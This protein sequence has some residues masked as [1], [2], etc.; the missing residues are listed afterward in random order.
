MDQADSFR[1]SDDELTK[2]EKGC[3]SSSKAQTLTEGM[4]GP[5]LGPL[6][7]MG[8]F[9]PLVQHVMDLQ[10]LEVLLILPHLVLPDWQSNPG[11]QHTNIRV[12]RV[13]TC[14]L[15]LMCK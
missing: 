2:W 15:S 14:S 9:T 3:E 4:I 7:A 6:K 12:Y 13:R 8:P 10:L 11:P 5:S 1:I